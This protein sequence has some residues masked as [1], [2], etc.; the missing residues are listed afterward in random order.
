MNFGRVVSPGLFSKM[1][2]YPFLILS[3]ALGSAAALDADT[4]LGLQKALLEVSQDVNARS[5]SGVTRKLGLKDTAPAVVRVYTQKELKR[6]ASVY[7]LL[8]TVPGVEVAD[9]AF[10]RQYIHIRNVNSSLYNNKV[11]FLINGFRVHDPTGP[12]FNLDL[13]PQNSIQRLEVICGA[14]S[15][16]Y[17]NNAYAGIIHVETF[18]SHGYQ[19]NTLEFVAGNSGVMGINGSLTEKTPSGGHFFAFELFSEN[20]RDR[21]SKEDY[22]R[23]SRVANGFS[24]I[25][26][27]SGFVRTYPGS[28]SDLKLDYDNS[29]FFGE[30]RFGDTSLHYGHS[31]VYRDL[32]YQEDARIPF[33]GG[34]YEEARNIGPSHPLYRPPNIYLP[35]SFDQVGRRQIDSHQSQSWVGLERKFELSSRLNLRLMGSYTDSE[36]IIDSHDFYLFRLDSKSRSAELDLQFE[37]KASERLDILGGFQREVMHFGQVTSGTDLRRTALGLSG[38]VLP[39]DFYQNVLPGSLAVE[40]IYLQGIYHFRPDLSLL[41]ANRRNAH[42]TLDPVYTPKIALSWEISSGEVLK[43]I[44]GKAIRYPSPFEL[45]ANLPLVQF[46]GSSMLREEEMESR[47]IHYSRSFAGNE[48]RLGVTLFDL[49]L[50]NLL[51]PGSMTYRN[52]TWETEAHG[53]ELE[54][55]Q[56]L[57]SRLVL[58]SNLTLM[59]QDEN[60]QTT[61]FSAG[62]VHHMGMLQLNYDLARKLQLNWL[63]RYIGPRRHDRRTGLGVEGTT[64]RHDLGLNWKQ[65]SSHEIDLRVENLFDQDWA[66]IYQQIESHH[67]PT[68]AR[69]RRITLSYRI[70]F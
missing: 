60:R 16:L 28:A 22:E 59:D 2:I 30:S 23:H 24:G 55:G 44:W 50:Q 11:L 38:T 51:V 52:N 37:Y 10:G 54:W 15:V 41:M 57:S 70:S 4:S 65:S 56:R 48:G 67:M 14:G 34:I 17:G 6:F 13:I 58:H 21:A 53:V 27:G 19:P 7:D 49:R 32:S 69:G 26:N 61:G 25:L 5:T 46:R 29:S 3:G 39:G 43:F 36:E 33:W 35:S 20:G 12:H 40:G 64:F 1:R 66:T 42:S 68:P 63:S 8:R 47:E 31:R 45:Y 9:G 62:E 18:D